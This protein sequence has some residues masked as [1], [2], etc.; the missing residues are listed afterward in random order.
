MNDQWYPEESSYST[1]DSFCGREPAN[2]LLGSASPSSL[3]SQ[4]QE[5]L[6]EDCELEATFWKRAG[7]LADR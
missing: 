6:G 7:C 2:A 5:L 1:A 4:I 3:A